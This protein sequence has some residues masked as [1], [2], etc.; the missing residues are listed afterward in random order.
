[1]DWREVAAMRV[2]RCLASRFDNDAL[3]TT[4]NDTPAM[5]TPLTLKALRFS[6]LVETEDREALSG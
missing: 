5:D 6:R 3:P 2:A 1:M 4:S